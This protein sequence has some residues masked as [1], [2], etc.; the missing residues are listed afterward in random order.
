MILL[1]ALEDTIY[2]FVGYV[3]DTYKFNLTV[4]LLQQLKSDSSIVEELNRQKTQKKGGVAPGDHNRVDSLSIL[5]PSLIRSATETD[6][7]TG[8]AVRGSPKGDLHVE[9]YMGERRLWKLSGKLHLLLSPKYVTLLRSYFTGI[10]VEGHKES[11]KGVLFLTNFRIVFVPVNMQLRDDPFLIDLFNIPLGNLHG[12][13]FSAMC[14][15]A[16]LK[17]AL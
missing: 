11:V 8:E 17:F 4:P 12:I 14:V 2:M 16:F 13:L 1:G 7:T 5:S 15:F 10:V 6:H 9:T 3:N